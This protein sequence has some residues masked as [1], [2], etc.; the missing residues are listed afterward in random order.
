MSADFLLL[1]ASI[2]IRGVQEVDANYFYEASNFS[3][4]QELQNAA[5]SA[6]IEAIETSDT[7]TKTT[8]SKNLGEISVRIGWKQEDIGQFFVD[9]YISNNRVKYTEGTSK[10]GTVFVAVASCENKRIGGKMYR[11]ALAYVVDND[12]EKI[13]H[14]L[15]HT[16]QEPAVK[17]N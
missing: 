17:N 13:I 2:M 6:L 14:Y 9:E 12:T 8:Y 10:N 11:R 3:A 4:E 5:D 16:N 7:S 15:N 1:V